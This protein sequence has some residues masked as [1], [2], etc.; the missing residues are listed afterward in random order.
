MGEYFSHAAACIIG[1]QL[2]DRFLLR[3]GALK[4][5]RLADG[6]YCIADSFPLCILLSLMDSFARKNRIWRAPTQ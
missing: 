1:V 5:R 6:E 4:A 3:K 2:N